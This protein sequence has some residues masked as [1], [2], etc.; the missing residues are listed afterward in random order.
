[1]A[2]ERFKKPEVRKSTSA[3]FRNAHT[4]GAV[5][6]TTA[7]IERLPAVTLSQ[8]SLWRALEIVEGRNRK[9]IVGRSLLRTED[10]CLQYG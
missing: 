8:N 9:V 5:G 6:H 3:R 10:A 7:L 2:R 1:M 4:A